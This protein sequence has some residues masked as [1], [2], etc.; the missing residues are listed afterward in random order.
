MVLC[1][2]NLMQLKELRLSA[3]CTSATFIF[4]SCYFLLDW[5][6]FLSERDKRID[7]HLALKSQVTS[8]LI[9]KVVLPVSRF[10]KVFM[11]YL[12]FISV[13]NIPS[14]H[15]NRNQPSFMSVPRRSFVLHKVIVWVDFFATSYNYWAT[16]FFH[17]ENNS[18]ISLFSLCP[19]FHFWFTEHHSSGQVSTKCIQHTLCNMNLNVCPPVLYS[20]FAEMAAGNQSF[21]LP[22][23]LPFGAMFSFLPKII[24]GIII[25]A[26][27]H[28]YST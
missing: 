12:C 11:W 15:C 21:P 14:F 20:D 2:R 27:P 25:I 1:E 26:H 5:I 10:L 4:L 23:F 28:G 19:C 6:L 8:A 3:C 24:Y 22:S 7:N 17:S 16:S 9:F 13:N 18:K